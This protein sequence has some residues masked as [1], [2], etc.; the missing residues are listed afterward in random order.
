VNENKE[1]PDKAFQL[2]LLSII[3]ACNLMRHGNK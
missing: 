3:T 2:T 1:Q